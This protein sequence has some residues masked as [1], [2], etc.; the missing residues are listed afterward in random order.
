MDEDE[1]RIE[2]SQAAAFRRKCRRTE[3]DPR[4]ACLPAVRIRGPLQAELTRCGGARSVLGGQDF[5]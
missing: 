1:L 2:L 3:G 4:R 5:S